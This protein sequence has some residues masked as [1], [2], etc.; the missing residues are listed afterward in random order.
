MVSH[1]IPKSATEF[2]GKWEASCEIRHG[3]YGPWIFSMS[4]S[5]TCISPKVHVCCYLDLL[6][7]TF[8][9]LTLPWWSRTSRLPPEGLYFHLHSTYR[10][11]PD[12]KIKKTEK[13][14]QSDDPYEQH[15]G[16]NGEEKLVLTGR[17][18]QQ[19]SGR[20]GWLEEDNMKTH[21]GREPEV[22]IS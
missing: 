12:N 3:R 14:Q 19:S 6:L 11:R 7:A 9:P 17:N 18:L 4:C 21:C 15:F 8:A 5:T 10:W 1:S 16:D 2:Y 13:T 20:G 22:N